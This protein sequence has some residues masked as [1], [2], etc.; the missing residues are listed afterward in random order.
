MHHTDWRLVNNKTEK[1]F[2]LSKREKKNRIQ[3]KVNTLDVSWAGMELGFE[4]GGGGEHNQ[5]NFCQYRFYTTKI[6]IH[7]LISYLCMY[8]NINF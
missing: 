4:P 2:C 7:I 5:K 1:F 6:C 3:E 8:Y